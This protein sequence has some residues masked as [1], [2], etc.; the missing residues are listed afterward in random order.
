MK[1]R[2]VFLDSEGD[3]WHE[4][5]ADAAMLGR[6]PASDPLLRKIVGLPI[7]GG[8]APRLLEIGCGAGAML[9]WLTEHRGFECVGI[10]PSPLAIAAA[11]ARGVTAVRGSAEQL[12]FDD[13]S[14]DIVAFGFCLY[15]CDREDLFRIAAEADRVLATNGWLLIFDFYSPTPVKRP[16]HHHPGVFSYKMDYR[17]LF[18][19]HPAYTAVSHDVLH[20]AT[21]A[22]T[23]DVDEWVGLSLLRKSFDRV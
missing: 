3:A 17:T 9:A 19:W 5:N 23:D 15:L 16:Y 2:D 14:F 1:Q 8:V 21:G 11:A 18:T 13:G 6:T 10:D 12:P 7:D 4:R 22:L 20:H